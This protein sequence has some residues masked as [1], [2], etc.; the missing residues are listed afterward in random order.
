MPTSIIQLF[1]SEQ[2]IIVMFL[3]WVLISAMFMVFHL[4]G[5]KSKRTRGGVDPKREE[6]PEHE[7]RSNE[8]GRL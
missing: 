3:M 8:R 1:N 5:K 4:D 7:H 2:L 6:L